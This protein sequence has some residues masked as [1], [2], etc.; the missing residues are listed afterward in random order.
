M[1][2]NEFRRKHQKHCFHQIEFFDI[3]YFFNACRKICVKI[4]VVACTY[5]GIL[6]IRNKL[7]KDL[8]ANII[9]SSRS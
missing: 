8:K 5:L 7:V 6:L 4:V 2:I 9:H 1:S 3:E